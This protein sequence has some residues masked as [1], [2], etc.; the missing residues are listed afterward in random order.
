VRRQRDECYVL[1]THELGDADLIVTLFAERHGKVRGVAPAARRSRRRF[2]GA[3]EPLTR[4]DASWIE[5]D[6][7]ELHRIEELACH[8]SYATLQGEPLGQAACAVLAEITSCFAHEGEA[9]PR[10]FRLVGAV[11]DALDRGG[12]PRTLL[13]YFEFWT[14]RLHGLL[15]EL[16]RCTGCG[17]EV[18]DAG[19]AWIAPGAGLRCVGCGTG[20]A[21]GTR[22]LTP[23]ERRLLD[24]LRRSAPGDLVAGPA[25]AVAAIEAL[26]RGVLEGFAERG[27]RTYRHFHAAATFARRAER[28]G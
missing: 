12:D 9:D 19:P 5:R 13:R 23:A 1:E 6:G 24:A 17:Q 26:L 18:E 22:R 20:A 14:L 28:A 25:R 3:L 11:L 21:A 27:F 16:D 8:R 15:P 10:G 7:R 2:G 4:V